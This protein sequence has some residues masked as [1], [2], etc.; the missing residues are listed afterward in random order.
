[1]ERRWSRPA[2]GRRLAAK[3]GRCAVSAV[4]RARQR[5]PR[6]PHRGRPESRVL[7][8]RTFRARADGQRD[9]ARLDVGGDGQ[10]GLCRHARTRRRGDRR[11]RSRH[12]TRTARRRSRSATRLS[13]RSGSRRQTPSRR[14]SLKA[15]SGSVGSRI[16]LNRRSTIDCRPFLIG[17]K[18]MTTTSVVST[19]TASERLAG[20]GNEQS[21][22]EHHGRGIDTGQDGRQGDV[23]ERAIDDQVDVVEVVAKDGHAGRDRQPAERQD[24]DRLRPLDIDEA[25][26]CRERGDGGRERDPPELQTLD[27][28][29]AAI[30]HR[31][32]TRRP[33][34]V[35]TRARPDGE[36]RRCRIA[37]SCRIRR[38]LMTQLEVGQRAWHER[39]DQDA[40]RH[41]R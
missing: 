19:K 29:S 23:D 21:L 2:T 38:G 6:P 30:P 25:E 40:D 41:R 26:R 20:Q 3:S 36:R 1:M 12:P 24:E 33:A 37:R 35:T 10:L 32:G 39:R 8:R 18:T 7:V 4:P 11:G 34:R 27:R 15:A 5:R 17:V 9:A 13:T 22:H 14:R 16:S 28:P 31:P